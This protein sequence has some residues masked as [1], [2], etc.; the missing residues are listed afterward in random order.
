MSDMTDAAFRNQSWGSR[1]QQ[2]G[3]QAEGQFEDWMTT[4]VKAG[5]VRFGLDRPPIAVHMLPLKLRY[6]P[7]FLTSKRL[8]EVKGFGRDRIAKVKVENEQALWEWDCDMPTRIWFYNSHDHKAWTLDVKGAALDGAWN[9]CQVASFPEGKD[10][11]EV[12]YGWLDEW[13]KPVKLRS[14]EDQQGF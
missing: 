9:A 14:R 11:Y 12:T 6:T 4:V 7:D 1:F 5:Y 3:D 10:Y 8:Y 13:A 2:M